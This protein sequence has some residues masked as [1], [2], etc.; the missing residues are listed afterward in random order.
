MKG[1]IEMNENDKAAVFKKIG[2]LLD[3]QGFEVN[4]KDFNR[5]WGGFF[6]LKEENAP[7]FINTYFPDIDIKDLTVGRRM[8]PKIL[9]VAPQ[10]RLSWQYHNRR[11]EV[12]RVVGGKVGLVKSPTDIQGPVEELQIGQTVI[13]DKGMRHRLV[14]LDTFG[15]VAE[16]WLHT[17]PENP[18][19]EEDIIRLED[20]FGREE[21]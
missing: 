14:G 9:I 7:H 1:V 18:S 13:L 16:I 10:K 20:D 2:K 6:V 21:K 12:W 8:S 4:R 3:E 11:S 19:D 15:L 5:P 17:D